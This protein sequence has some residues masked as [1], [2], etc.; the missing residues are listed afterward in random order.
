MENSMNEH[1]DNWYFAAAIV[2]AMLLVAAIIG[3]IG[4]IIS[5]WIL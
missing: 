4:P 3:A 2:I 5:D 1:D